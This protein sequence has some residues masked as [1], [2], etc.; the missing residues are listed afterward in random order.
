MEDSVVI[1]MRGVSKSFGNNKAND[2]VD[3]E[4]RKGEILAILGEN[5]AGKSTLMKILFGFYTRDEGTVE[6]EGN[7]MPLVY[8]PRVAMEMG[9]AMVHQHFKLVETLPVAENIV[10]GAEGK[11]ARFVYDKRKTR[12]KLKSLY[13]YSG[14]HLNSDTLIRDLPLGD[15]QKVEILK[16]LFR[17]CRTLILDEPT[18][19]L[20]PQ[21][22][23]NMFSLLKNLREQGMTVLIITHKLS[24][25]LQLSD[26]V[27][28]M[29]A[30]RVAGLFE[31]SHTS[32]A[33]LART[34]VGY[35][36]GSS[37]TIRQ[38]CSALSP[39]LQLENLSTEDSAG[40]NLKGLSLSLYP[41]RIVGIAGV[42]GNGQREL[43]EVLAGILPLS[44]GTVLLNGSL[45]DI[46]RR[47]LAE[48]G[49]RIIPEDR[50]RQGLVLPLTVQ[51]NI[52]AGY[53]NRIDMRK[54]PFFDME[55]IHSFTDGLIE[56]FDIRPRSRELK[57]QQMSGGNQQKIVLAREL[58]ESDLSIIVASQPTR[59][60]DVGAI[61]FTHSQLLKHKNE[62]RTILLIS[63]D[64][65]EI[66]ALSD[67]I[68]VIYDGK[69]TVQRNAD[70]FDRTTLGLYMGGGREDVV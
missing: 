8:S 63:S 12:E 6:I 29:R 65:D 60:L 48:S 34:M 53:R 38:S 43:V 25:V 16:A 5:G 59:G 14:I 30:G 1:R 22:T 54:G 32:E 3:M 50:H 2:N 52:M 64:L 45:F 69:I 51:D 24:E 57:A 36:L 68:A 7:V 9:L 47:K 70:D 42:D 26:R 4:V 18:A 27:L 21:E 17:G 44:S 39:T 31:T 67:E 28:V 13:D 55:A 23:E 33:E 19:V 56:D 66:E 35:E 49:L 10:L 37:K 15:R 20:T 61:E 40:C 11:V 58:S 46:G 62:G 41:G